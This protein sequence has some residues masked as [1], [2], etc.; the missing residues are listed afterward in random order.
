VAIKRLLQGSAIRVVS[1]T[2]HILSLLIILPLM[3]KHFGAE[4]YGLWSLIIALTNYWMLLDFG[5]TPTISRYIARLKEKND[6]SEIRGYFSSAL[7]L[8]LIITILSLLLTLIGYLS[9]PYFYSGELLDISRW[10]LLIVGVELSF[11]I[12]MKM[13][14]GVMRGYLLYDKLALFEIV[15]I[16]LRTVLFILLLTNDYGVIAVAFTNAVVNW[17]WQGLAIVYVFRHMPAI[18]FDRKL[19]SIQKIKELT[20]FSYFIFISN[21]TGL[22]RFNILPLVIGF[23][24]GLVAVALLSVAMRLIE[25]F[26]NLILRIVGVFEPYFAQL[27]TSQD[28]TP[29]ANLYFRLTRATYFLGAI[30]VGNFFVIGD[31]F[32]VRWVGEDFRSSADVLV[33]LGVAFFFYLASNPTTYVMRAI[34]K[35]KRFAYI[36]VWE[37]LAI[38]FLAIIITPIWG[39]YGATISLMIP[40]II[41]SLGIKNRIVINELD[42]D[43]GSYFKRIGMEIL[44]Y[45]G[46]FLLIWWL[47]SDVSSQV[48]FGYLKILLLCCIDT[49]LLTAIMY[50]TL[51]QFE[52]SVLKTQF[53]KIL[54]KLPTAH[55]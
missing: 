27:S 54:K 38:T 20:K 47:V 16:F 21:L 52:K 50:F 26:N 18:H 48:N 45:F 36:E 4:V 44:I 12:P 15:R 30:V 43:L 24:E 7:T 37:G 32:I 17:L 14:M 31:T 51:D 25:A 23:F 40:L 46:Y 53:K 34:N 42:M 1:L 8:S 35:H 55:R 19:I 5:I 39:L 3:V 10:L 49:L 6:V 2:L 22:A 41:V 28:K 9:L 33:L 11:S 29:I 13:N